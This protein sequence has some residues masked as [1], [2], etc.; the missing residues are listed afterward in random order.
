M[1]PPRRKSP[2][3]PRKAER[4]P[5]AIRIPPSSVQL[6]ISAPA[7]HSLV[8]RV[9]NA[10]VGAV[11]RRPPGAAGA[12]VTKPREG[13]RVRKAKEPES[14][15][16]LRSR[17]ELQASDRQMASCCR[18]VSAS[19]LAIGIAY[20]LR[21]FAIVGYRSARDRRSYPLRHDFGHREQLQQRAFD[22]RLASCRSDLRAEQI[23][24]IKHIDHPLAERRHMRRRDVE[25]ELRQGC[26]KFVEQSRAV[27]PDHLDHGVA[28]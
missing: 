22:C 13:P 14:L 4:L 17:A 28:V 21:R 9:T 3:R 23:G 10:A 24:H 6:A 26:R 12:A 27:E 25:I 16:S 7:C 5:L 20:G 11:A 2:L 8:V 18:T 1:P 15:L 19:S